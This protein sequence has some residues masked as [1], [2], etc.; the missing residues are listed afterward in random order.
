MTEEMNNEFKD[1]P[2]IVWT[3]LI[4]A[5]LFACYFIGYNNGADSMTKLTENEIALNIENMAFSQQLPYYA[6]TDMITLGDL[7][8]IYQRYLPLSRSM[9]SQYSY[10]ICYTKPESD[11]NIDD[12]TKQISWIG[13]QELRGICNEVSR[14]YNNTEK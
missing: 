4:I 13:L 6:R 7:R 3:V 12:S 9:L 1:K 10:K 8:A 2:W 5:A 11:R 14:Q